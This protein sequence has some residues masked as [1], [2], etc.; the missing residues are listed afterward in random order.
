[1]GKGWS[2]IGLRARPFLRTD[3]SDLEARISPGRPHT[4]LPKPEAEAR[5]QLLV[6]LSTATKVE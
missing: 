6:R 5:Y 3:S 1:M 2:P 4:P